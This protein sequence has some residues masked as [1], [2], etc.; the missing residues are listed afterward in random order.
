[1]GTTYI[2]S[3]THD[4]GT[5]NMHGKRLNRR[6]CRSL[7]ERPCYLKIT[8]NGYETKVSVRYVYRD[9][10]LAQQQDHPHSLNSRNNTRTSNEHSRSWAT[11]WP[12]DNGRFPTPLYHLH[13]IIPPLS[14]VLCAFYGVR[15]CFRATQAPVLK[16]WRTKQL[17]PKRLG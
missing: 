15:R 6:L 1:M 2:L 3:R 17:P 16:R 8:P 4:P 9:S 13:N 14:R 10:E 5:D 7:Y 11:S 12:W